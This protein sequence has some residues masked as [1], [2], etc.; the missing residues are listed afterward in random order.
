ML[1]FFNFMLRIL[2]EKLIIPVVEN[3]SSFILPLRYKYFDQ[4]RLK[5]DLNFF[6]VFCK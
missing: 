4:L 3:I 6:L 1:E 2:M 5:L